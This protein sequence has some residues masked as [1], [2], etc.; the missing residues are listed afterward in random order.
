MKKVAFE[1]LGFKLN[2]SEISS[3]RRDFENEGF[4]LCKLYEEAYIYV[5]N[6]CSGTIGP[7]TVKSET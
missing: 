4:E 6:T 3:M 7:M 2:F 5:I 1:T